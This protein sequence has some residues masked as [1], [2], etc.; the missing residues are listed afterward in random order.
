MI[1]TRPTRLDEPNHRK[2]RSF[3]T[4]RS[5]S[6]V[7]LFAI[8]LGPT[9]LIGLTDAEGD[10]LNYTVDVLG[11]TLE[12]AN[13]RT[14]EV[15]P[16]ATRVN[17]T[18]YV[19]VTELVAAAIVPPAT[20]VSGTIHLDYGDAEVLVEANGVAKEAV[21]TDLDDIELGQT[22]LKIVLSNRDHLIV[23]K[24]RAHLLQL[25]FDL[26]ASH[27]VNIEPMPA[28]AAAQQFIA[29]EVHPVDEKDF[30]V[31]GPLVAVSEDE[32]SYTVAVRPFHDR[33]TDFGRFTVFVTDDTEFEVNGDIWAGAEGLRALSAAGQG[34]PT[35]AKGTLTTS[36]RRFTADLV[37]AGHVHFQVAVQKPEHCHKNHFE[38][39]VF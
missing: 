26:E 38:H 35:I 2:G 17:F 33:V 3:M 36:D 7:A 39:L 13:G 28:R 37:L 5:R 21:V 34:T 18:E 10:F 16:N 27:E 30:R 22:S 25:D 31:R 20:Y 1:R 12:T 6:N 29:A 4:N 23:T 8:M 9:V 19:D 15:M 32:M 11:L 24:R 14:V